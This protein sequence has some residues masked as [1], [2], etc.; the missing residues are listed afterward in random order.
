[1]CSHNPYTISLN[2]TQVTGTGDCT[3]EQWVTSDL[4]Y[5]ELK[6]DQTYTLTVGADS[7]S[8]HINFVVPD[9]Y[10]LEIDGI[11]AKS[12]DKVGTT[13]GGGD[14]SWNVV[15]RQKCSCGDGGPGES[16][17]PKRGSVLWQVGMGT[18]SNGMTA[19]SINLREKALSVLAYTPAALVYSPPGRTNEV[20]V[21]RNADQSLRQVKAPQALA[22]VIVISA[23]EY[24]I[25][26][27]SSADVGSKV[28]GLYTL[29]GQPFVKWKIKN[30]D[31][32]T[33]TRLQI[34]KT[35]GAV[36]DTS[37]YTWDAISDSWTLST[38]NGARIETS[39]ITY[40]TST[41]RVETIVVKD[42]VPLITS[43]LSRTYHTFTWGEELIQE[44]L[45]P[46]NAALKTVYSYYENQSETGK[47]TRLKSIVNPDGSWEKY[48]YD[49]AG[50][51]VL[52]LRPWKD[53]SIGTAT[54]DSSHTTLYTYSNS[55]GIITSL[56]TNLLSSETE[57]IAGIIVRKR[58]YSRT[59]TTVDE[60]PAVIESETSYF[61]A[62]E[63]LVR[64]TTRYHSTAPPSLAN[65]LVAIE[66]PDGRKKSLTYEKG[67][68]VPNAD[69]ALSTFTPDVNGLAERETMVS[70]TVA[71]PQ[72]VA[73]KTT[74]D[75]YIRD[76]N[77]NQVLQESYIYN[78]TTYERVAWVAVEY[79]QRGH[80]VMA[81]TSKG[82]MS[83]AVW[84][85]DLKSSEI[86][87][88]GI[89]TTYVYDS[90]NQLK[91]RTKKGIAAGGGFPAQADILTEFTY[92]VEGRQTSEKVSSSG[93]SVIRKR[94]YDIAGRLT[95][96]TDEA[97]LNT[98]YL[99]SNGG[100]IQT[101]L[102]PGGASEI[103]ESY[104]DGQP[105]S[106]TGSRVVSQYFDYGINTDGTQYMQEFVG[107]AGLS[108]PRWTRTTTDWVGRV[109]YVEAPSFTG[110]NVRQSSIYDTL[111]RL[112]KQITIAGTTKLVADRLFEYNEL[113][114]QIRSGF[115]IDGNGLLSLAST[116]RIDEA[117]SLFEKV[118]T[119]WFHTTT[120]RTYLTDN[121]STPTVQSQRERLSNFPL[122]GAD[123]TISEATTMNV[124][125]NSTVRTITVDRVAKKQ[126]TNV[127]TP[128]SNMN[129]I[130]ITI[131]GLLQSYVP[132]TPE[133]AT[134][135][136]YDALG[137]P[138]SVTDPRAGT[139]TRNYHPTA[140]QV[141]STNDGA[142]DT[143]YD[144]YPAN[145]VSAGKL[146]SQTNAAG[147]KVYFN[148]SSRGELLQTW[149]DTTYPIENV[150]DAY[151]QRTELHTFRAGQNW[152]SSSWP[153]A[154]TGAMDVTRWTYQDATGVVTQKRDAALKGPAYTY[155]ELGRPKTRL[156]ARGIT[157]TYGY[158]LNTGELR[159][160]S[161]SDGTPAASFSYD[162]GGRQTDITDAGGSRV[163]SFNV[164]G[165]LQSEQITGGILDGVG[166]TIGYDSFLRRNS[167][168]S[169]QGVNTLTSQTYGYDASSRLQTVAKGSQTATYAYYPNT[170]LL[171]TTSFTGGTS[172]S[173]TYDSIGR[174][175]SITNTPAA[176]VAQSFA[177]APNN[178]NQRTRIT[179]EDGSYWSYIYND[180]GELNSGKKFWADN[181]IV[182]GAQT[183][184]S[185]DNLGNRIYARNGGNQ[186]GTLRQSFYTTNSSNQSTQRTVPGTFD[187]RGTANTQASVAVNNQ[188]AAR[189]GDY[190]YKEQAVDNS[191]APV[192]APVT[193]VG[194][195]NNFGA[196]GEDAVSEKGGRVFV[197]K[198]P[199]A[200]TYDDDGNLT[201][202]GRW[203]YTWDAE[204]RLTSM[205]AV[206]GVPVEAKMKLE[207][208][209]EHLGP[210]IQKKV[211]GWN[212]TSGQY[213][214]QST[215]RFVYDGWDLIAEINDNP[216]LTRTYVRAG[217][218]LL[219]I[220]SGGESYQVGYDGNQNVSILMKANTGVV[221]ASYEYDPFGR[222]LTVVGEY[223]S[224]NPFRFSGEY[225]DTETGLINYGYR[226]YNPD[227]GRWINRDPSEEEGGIN[228]YG[229]LANDGINSTDHL[230]LWKKNGKWT[231]RW[232]RY[233]GSAIA[234]DCDDLKK[235]AEYITGYQ[236]DWTLLRIPNTVKKGQVVNIA[237]LLVQLE[238]R[239][240]DSVVAATGKFNG[241][242]FDA[243]QIDIEEQTLIDPETGRDI[244]YRRPTA[245]EDAIRKFFGPTPY[246]SADCD[247]AASLVM[248]MGLIDVL[249]RGEFDR[250][251]HSAM[252]TQ[253]RGMISN[254]DLGDRG[255]FPN[256]S[257]YLQKNSAN[258]VIVGGFWMQENVIKVGA[259]QYWGFIGRDRE[260]RLLQTVRTQNEWEELLRTAYNQE[261]HRNR[262]SPIPGFS[263]PIAITFLDSARIASQVF[264]MRNEKK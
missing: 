45:D 99:Y 128:E 92:D 76:L 264:E 161:Y 18:L 37:E 142:G 232:K 150:Y 145:H 205:E 136:L 107:P 104:V 230:G 167:L 228:L 43:K 78:G 175:Q 186:L 11:E 225:A 85:G 194:A 152:S 248:Q 121:N 105:K 65:R 244:P 89:E 2:G 190:F 94:A 41:S 115:D 124:A 214:V 96:E 237:P 261:R 30:P 47:Y 63:S 102:R 46:D 183:E 223:A 147:K 208:A 44:V 196:G 108:S 117:E 227:T 192:Y 200:F 122:N 126:V 112:Q 258:V 159:T 202:D 111:G 253:K 51:M 8:T 178:L 109:I 36:T 149:G 137:R 204:N 246:G 221:S 7:C 209:Y 3:A 193:I 220:D 188:A 73:F 123:Q 132:T 144:Y 80:A 259:N 226:Y 165:Q 187:V 13:E 218:Q 55:D 139:S 247:S 163:R 169:F 189:K 64:T 5:T 56:Y 236:E 245:F 199:E 195:R 14:G 116:D 172:I 255:G 86:D 140:G 97:D 20:D 52:V 15:L 33:T 38:G 224:Q 50:N 77:G 118:G 98:I 87:T 177:Y 171:N 48:D 119:D 60:H 239:L 62:T 131:N 242:T 16:P 151:G 54:E 238:K 251:D 135:Y 158:D 25:R 90:L 168:L 113:G 207:F 6:V 40:P 229:F 182:W 129:A 263:R 203:T 134:T 180:R 262:R 170:G 39:T 211:Y 157:T 125:G 181:S 197:P 231:G 179:R 127:D 84:T 141:T 57:K 198:A 154:T 61:S 185:F 191:T 71:S 210:R 27:Y 234:D 222:T 100:R 4:T 143:L 240:R 88:T 260:G 26:Y 29:T 1:M 19:H 10:K 254:M 216:A 28:G 184:Y 101:V 106:I 75:V 130:S 70:G 83:T 133:S 176:D 110:T 49:N 241:K 256:Y 250:L 249:R 67:N 59:G 9:G 160:V 95:K 17:G 24:E 174:L 156:S 213:A 34:S 66:Y 103:S 58:T 82:E 148:Y 68:Y 72:G 252:F 215:T 79:D 164:A 233:S 257:D 162:R 32:A 153:T 31:P 74:K 23:T 217:R 114:E 21:V 243:T 81:R 22:D 120:F 155:D 235:L 219:L 93:L 212:V 138:I 206:P 173:R 69:P 166:V 12:I 91:S 35:Q 42:N 146:K 53:Q 201:S